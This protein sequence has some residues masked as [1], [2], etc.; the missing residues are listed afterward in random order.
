MPSVP[1]RDLVELAAGAIADLPTSYEATPDTLN[2]LLAQENLNPLSPDDP[3]PHLT[4]DEIAINI[5]VYF[6][7]SPGQTETLATSRLMTTLPSP[8]FPK[9]VKA[10]SHFRISLKLYSDS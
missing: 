1:F 2:E 4:L 5:P 9:S 6:H 3:F 8:L 10:L 7:V